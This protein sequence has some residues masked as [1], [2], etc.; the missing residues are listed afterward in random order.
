MNTYTLT[1]VVEETLISVYTVEVRA[2]SVNQAQKIAE[3]EDMN[4]NWV[5]DSS[6]MQNS[7]TLSMSVEK[8]DR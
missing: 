1:K 5:E 6:E 8:V 7:E 4:L 2:E 3:A